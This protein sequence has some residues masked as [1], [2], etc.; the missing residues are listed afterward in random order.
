MLI[1]ELEGAKGLLMRGLADMLLEEVQSSFVQSFENAGFLGQVSR[2][3]DGVTADFQL[4][5]DIRN[6]QILA[7][8]ILNS[9]SRNFK[10]LHAQFLNSCTRNF[11]LLHAQISNSCT[12]K[13]KTL[14]RPI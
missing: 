6:F 9:C 4:V 3:V 13:F 5:T 10:L 12:C 8:V 2:P 1:E 7:R 14:A 11:K